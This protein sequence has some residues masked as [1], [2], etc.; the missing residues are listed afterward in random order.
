MVG[1]FAI[2]IVLAVAFHALGTHQEAAK[3]A[4]ISEVHVKA[5]EKM[6]IDTP[7]IPKPVTEPLTASP[8][9]IIEVK[10]AAPQEVVAPPPEVPAPVERV[11]PQ[12]QPTDPE[13][14]AW[15]YFVGQGFSR[16]QTAGILGNLQQEHGFSTSD[17]PGG[18]GIA[19]WLGAR[20]ANLIAKGNHLDINVQ[21]AF[22][23][24]ELNGVEGRAMGMLRAAGSVEAATIAFQNGYERCGNCQQQTRIQYAYGILGRH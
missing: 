14:I 16:E 10:P 17:V 19:Q 5:A 15:N 18:L 2:G 4:K 22:I 23:M 20:R 24:E 11:I 21:L 13:T 8:A 6:T 3:F 9:P 12:T 1:K 7:I